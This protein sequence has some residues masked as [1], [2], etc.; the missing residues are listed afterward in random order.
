MTCYGGDRSAQSSGRFVV[1]AF[2]ESERGAAT[3]FIV[4]MFTLMIAFSG[5]VI[6]VGRIMNIHSQA[7]S[8][9]DRAA[10]AAAAEL[11]GEA[12]A[13]TRAVRAA[14]GD[15]VD[16]PL[17]PEGFRFS[18]SGDNAVSISRMV[19]FSSITDDDGDPYARSPLP[20]DV[21]VCDWTLAGGFDCSAYGLTEA[22]A[23]AVAAFVLVEATTETENYIMF[24]IAAVF[25]PGIATEASVAPQAV[26]GFRQEVCN[27]P[28]LAI[29]NPYENPGGGGAFNPI[30]GQQILLKTKGSGASWAPGNFGLL[31]LSSDAGGTLCNGAS[32]SAAFIR[33][34]LS[35]EN[36]NTRCV[37]TRVS[38]SPGEKQT[39]HNG[40][41]VR[42][43][44][45][46]PP[47]SRTDPNTPPS[48]NVTK[49]VTFDGNNCQTNK[50]EAAEEGSPEETTAL[51]RDPCF[52]NDTCAGASGEPRFGD[53]VNDAILNDYWL[54]NHGV[55]LPGALSGGTR[56]DV[57]R[58]E[59]DTPDMTDKSAIGGEDGNPSC[60]TAAPVNNPLLDRRV[61][62]VAVMNCI[63]HGVSGNS[64]NVPVEDFMQV[65]L[66]EPIG[67]EAANED[68][69][70]GEVLGVVDP[71]AD[72]GV[73]HEFPVLY[74]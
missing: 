16:G 48:A 18:L 60:S 62:I 25:A 65:F 43:D 1:A 29:C 23:N 15:G 54:T 53:G 20:G 42:F 10:L 34:V 36:P 41:N 12:G 38:T 69:I 47:L 7:S 11:D 26:A 6:D 4:V 21:E 51:P 44:I 74:R 32:G 9:V 61:L 3:V 71:G 31:Q 49:G 46:D 59:I 28:P 14:F 55:T 8:Y 52:S 63:E 19:F 67:Y 70:Y 72:D 33:C 5:M 17:V 24:P 37:S 73:L 50:L 58:Y 40:L 64:A 13:M 22:E 39:I 57:Y 35:L 2:A 45:Y 30:I 56:Y 27:A 66:T 68:D